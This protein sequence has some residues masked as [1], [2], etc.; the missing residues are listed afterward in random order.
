MRLAILIATIALTACPGNTPPPKAPCDPA[1][2][3]AITASCS[4]KAFE[5]GK[6][7]IPKEECAPMISCNET[8]DKRAEE[9]RK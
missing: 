8:L 2:L 9:C 5:C 7:G 3:A 6:A 1:T 4:V